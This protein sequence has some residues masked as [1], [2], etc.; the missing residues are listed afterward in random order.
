M[1]L[2]VSSRSQN[3]NRIHLQQLEENEDEEKEPIDLKFTEQNT[4]PT[5][6]LLLTLAD[7]MYRK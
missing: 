6:K 7:R 4:D 2:L 5:M 3:L 1:W